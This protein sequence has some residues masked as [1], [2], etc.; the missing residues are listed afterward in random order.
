MTEVFSAERIDPSRLDA[1]QRE[2]LS[3]KLY[4]IHQRVFAGLDKEAFGHYV[5]NSAAKKTRILLYRNRRKEL[6]G[7]FGVHRFEK[8][9]D[10]QPLVV[11]RAEVGLLPGYRQSDAKLSFCWSEATRYKLLHPGKHVYLFFVP[12]SP[13]SYAV[14]ARYVHKVYP[15]R[16]LKIPADALRL[17]TQL[18]LQFGL[19]AVEEANPLVRKVGWITL[20]TRQ[21][22]D[23]WRSTG[24]PYVRFYVAA[25]PQFGEGNG[26]LTLIPMTLANT[27]LSLFGV[28]LHGL[29]KKLRAR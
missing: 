5:V 23:F 14:A 16:H 7:Y 11:F 20:A 6:I 17:M 26:L 25:N 27:L 9:V 21:E 3:E 8:E 28:G 2:A 24:N 4:E 29:K 10:G 1:R 22:Q 13:S 15:D 18:A 12:V 19:P